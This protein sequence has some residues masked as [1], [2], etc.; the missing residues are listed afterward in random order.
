MNRMYQEPRE[1]GSFM[2]NLIHELTCHSMS[3]RTLVVGD[4][5]MDQML[6]ENV[7]KFEPFVSQFQSRQCCNYS[8]HNLRGILDLIFDNRISEDV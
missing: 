1:V 5:N 4:F 8:T 2:N 6:H 7:E 3:N